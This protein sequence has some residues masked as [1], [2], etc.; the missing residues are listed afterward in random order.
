LLRVVSR[1][2]RE[3]FLNELNRSIRKLPEHERKEIE[4]D[5]IE[6]FEFAMADGKQEEEIAQALGSPQQIG[7]EL[8]ATYHL[9][10]VESKKSITSILHATWATIGLGFFNLVIVLGP[11]I[12]LLAIILSGWVVGGAFIL[13][14]ILVLISSFFF[15]ILFFFFVPFCS[16][17][18]FCFVFFIFICIYYV[19]GLLKYCFFKFFILK[20]K[21]KKR[22][23]PSS[24][25]PICLLFS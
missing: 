2:N 8:R 17:F 15:F 3:T 16:F 6:H 9:E 5:F 10:Q 1:M 22:G 7:K 12:A 21:F 18:L 13:S 4:Q 23:T 20:I 11:F 14:P 25:G 19:T 24:P